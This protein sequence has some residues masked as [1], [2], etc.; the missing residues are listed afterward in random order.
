MSAPIA[1]SIECPKCLRISFNADDIRHRYCGACHE[2]H[3]DMIGLALRIIS[4]TQRY[5][6]KDNETGDW[7]G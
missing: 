3:D 5:S 2:F 1:D 6:I 4:N 7:I